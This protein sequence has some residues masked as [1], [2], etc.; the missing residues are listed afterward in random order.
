MTKL[1]FFIVKLAFIVFVFCVPAQ[2]VYAGASIELVSPKSYAIFQRDAK[3]MAGVKVS[4]SLA[5][6]ADAIEARATASED[7]DGTDIKWTVI[8]QAPSEGV[9][10]AALQVPAGWYDIEVRA[11]KDKKTLDEVSVEYVGIGEV[12]ITAGQSNS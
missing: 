7:L 1:N 6:N 2:P 5:G 12:F 8:V 9:F 4:G 3:N 11:V 10:S